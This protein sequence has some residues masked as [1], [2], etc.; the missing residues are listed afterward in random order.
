MPTAYGHTSN[1][2]FRCSCSSRLPLALTAGGDWNA[3]P[4]TVFLGISRTQFR[5]RHSAVPFPYGRS[6]DQNEI[7]K[8]SSIC[9]E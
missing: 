3:R 6:G 5:R 7:S 2:H 8:M 9:H 1:H 4:F